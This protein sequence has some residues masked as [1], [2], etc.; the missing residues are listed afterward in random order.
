MKKSFMFKLIMVFICIVMII[1]STACSK[2]TDDSVTVNTNGSRS[3]DI[4]RRDES[5]NDSGTDDGN[6]SDDQKDDLGNENTADDVSDREPVDEGNDPIKEDISLSIYKVGSDLIATRSELISYDVNGH[7][8]YRSVRY[9]C[10]SEADAQILFDQGIN[11]EAKGWNF[12]IIGK[13]VFLLCEKE[14]FILSYFNKS[15]VVMKMKDWCV[16]RH[17]FPSMRS[18]GDVSG[19]GYVSKPLTEENYKP[20]GYGTFVYNRNLWHPDNHRLIIWRL[21]S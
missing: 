11:H 12:S 13:D 2:K 4:E 5:R 1:F 6:S 9:R 17:Y 3:N 20:C 18:N 8:V 15:G 16:G 14:T 21:L 19:I 7:G 10:A